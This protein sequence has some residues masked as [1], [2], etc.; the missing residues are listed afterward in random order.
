MNGRVLGSLSTILNFPS[1]LYLRV[2]NSPS[3]SFPSRRH[4]SAAD[5]T[6]SSMIGI[7]F[8]GS[9]AEK[10]AVAAPRDLDP[11]AKNVDKS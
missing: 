5:I 8:R 4:P 11:D 6:G 7:S 10:V 9:S 2:G 1:T 3:S